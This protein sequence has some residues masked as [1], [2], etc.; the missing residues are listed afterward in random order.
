MN[1][2]NQILSE[3]A[4]QVE[5][6]IAAFVSPVFSSHLLQIQEMTNVANQLI[7][8][9]K[10]KIILTH[11][12]RSILI[13]YIP[14]LVLVEGVATVLSDVLAFLAVIRQVWGLWKEKRGLG[15]HTGKDFATLLL[16]QVTGLVI[17]Y[18]V[19]V[20]VNA[21]QNVLS[22][23]LICGFTLDLRRRNTT[24]RSLPTRSALEFAD[25]NLSF[26]NNLEVRSVRSIFGRLQE[27]IIADMGERNGPVSFG[28]DAPG[29]G[30]ELDME[31]A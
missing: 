21:F 22:T 23:I 18:I 11:S 15:L 9:K 4:I 28:I 31:T 2:L 17:V 7:V 19:G 8:R 27:G 1:T 30:S 20:D 5:T 29:P 6:Y 13:A 26:H 24:T 10:P 12:E 25:L 14:I 16:Q 3:E